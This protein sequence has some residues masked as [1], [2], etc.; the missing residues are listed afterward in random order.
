MPHG[1][2]VDVSSLS[3]YLPS[4]HSAQVVEEDGCLPGGQEGAWTMVRSVL[5]KEPPQTIV[6]DPVGGVWEVDVMYPV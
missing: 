2:Q 3:L 1:V 5:V 6:H 4:V